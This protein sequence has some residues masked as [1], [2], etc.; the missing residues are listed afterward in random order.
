MEAAAG[1]GRSGR[2][3]GDGDGARLGSLEMRT[4][5]Q[6]LTA[7]LRFPEEDRKLTACRARNSGMRGRL[8]LTDAAQ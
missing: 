1:A 3:G 4:T 7:R 5:W 6:D 2:R 8:D